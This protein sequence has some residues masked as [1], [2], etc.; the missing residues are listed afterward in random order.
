MLEAEAPSPPPCPCLCCGSSTAAPLCQLSL[1][2]VLVLSHS[3]LLSLSL[4]VMSLSLFLS[5]SLCLPN[6]TTPASFKLQK[7]SFSEQQ[8]ALWCSHPINKAQAQLTS[9]E[10]ASEPREGRAHWLE[11]LISPLLSGVSL[12]CSQP[13]RGGHWHW[14]I[15]G[16]DHWA[17][18]PRLP[19]VSWP[20]SLPL[21][22]WCAG[23]IREG[24]GLSAHTTSYS[25]RALGQISAY[26][27]LEAVRASLF[28]GSA[29]G[30]KN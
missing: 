16:G 15:L 6:T 14:F 20:G 27:S 3:L 9:W 26:S 10:W 19:S 25:Q 21:S 18:P 1:L 13:W 23:K 8:A 29:G 11:K 12:H 17:V 7:P 22:H 30:V 4:S 24:P 2:C 28:C 5:L